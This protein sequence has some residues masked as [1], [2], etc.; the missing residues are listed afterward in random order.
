MDNRAARAARKTRSRYHQI[1][2]L[3]HKMANICVSLAHTSIIFSTIIKLIKSCVMEW[4]GRR[5][6]HRQQSQSKSEITAGGGSSQV[7]LYISRQFSAPPNSSLTRIDKRAAQA[8]KNTHYR[9]NQIA[10]LDHKMA[11]SCVSLARTNTVSSTITKLNKPRKTS[12]KS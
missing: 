5:T 6:G 1:G 2:P 9:Y 7:L 8:A 12:N 3:D 11:D 4:S 10:P